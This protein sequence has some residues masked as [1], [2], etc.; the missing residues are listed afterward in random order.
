MLRARVPAAVIAAMLVLTGCGT[1]DDVSDLSASKL[2]AKTKAAA[3]DAES[4]T[5]EGGGEAPGSAIEVDLEFTETTGQGT[6]AAGGGKIDLLSVDGTT[7]F[8]AGPEFFSRLGGPAAEAF[9][10]QIGDKWIAADSS[11]GTFGEFEKFANRDSFVDELLSQYDDAT[12]TAGKKVEGV[13]C[14]GLKAAPS[15]LWVAADGGRPISF[16]PAQGKSGAL[17]FGYDDVEAPDAPAKNEIVDDSPL[18]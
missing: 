15:T 2:L 5:V 6:I 14:I 10:D 1:G 9:A 4:L 13:D 18:G 3:K 7:Y 16:E 8:R 12:K 17:T 11:G